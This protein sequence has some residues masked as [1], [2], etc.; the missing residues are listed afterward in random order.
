MCD[1][2]QRAALLATA[3]S[4]RP[5]AKCIPLAA[6]T[7][8][9]RVKL[10]LQLAGFLPPQ[11]GQ[12]GLGDTANRNMPT[13]VTALDGHDIVAAA[14]GKFHTVFVTADG[15]SFTCG[16]NLQV[17]HQL[18]QEPRCVFCTR[19]NP[20]PHGEHPHYWCIT[21]PTLGRKTHCPVF[22]KGVEHE[23]CVTRYLWSLCMHRVSVAR[24]PSRAQR[25]MKV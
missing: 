20:L 19:G 2:S 10:R 24:G 14:A 4:A 11:K 21:R 15:R 18:F 22:E 6:T 23:K 8:V 16:S 7:C 1:S 5:T 17:R 25:T 13:L 9:H 3:S 12:L